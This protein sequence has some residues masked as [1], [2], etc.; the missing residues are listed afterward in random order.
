MSTAPRTTAR[1]G[2]AALTPAAPARAVSALGPRRVGGRY[3]SGAGDEYT[4]LE[5]Q[6][7]DGSEP[8]WSVT[9]ASDVEQAAGRRRTDRTAWNPTCD[10]VLHQ[11]AERPD[12]DTAGVELSP[13]G[14]YRY[15]L[16]RDWDPA[17]PRVTWVMLNP[18]TADATADDHTIRKCRAYSRAWHG[19]GLLVVNLFALR[20][21]DPTALYRDPDPIGPDTDAVLATRLTEPRTDRARVVVAWGRHGTL[22]GRDRQVLDLLHRLGISPQ[23]L[24]VIRNGRPGHP[25]R[26]AATLRPQPF[27]GGSRG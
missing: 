2:T 7:G 25:A 24:T 4:V 5:L 3:R 22:H 13:D 19:G 17:R 10:Q 18:S 21:T 23:C 15:A 26:L 9:V 12:E 14:R 1:A 8:H 11:P 6:P 16:T 20:A 27:P